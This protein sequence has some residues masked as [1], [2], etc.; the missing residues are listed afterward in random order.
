[1][2]RTEKLWRCDSNEETGILG[3]RPW[4][5]A[6]R[7]DRDLVIMEIVFAYA[8]GT[9]AADLE[10]QAAIIWANLAFDDTAKAALKRDGLAIEG[11]RLTGACP[12]KLRATDA[13]HVAVTAPGHGD[14]AALLDLWQI[15]FQRRIVLFGGQEAA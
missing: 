8:G 13:G 5:I 10:D 9:S 14:A 1:M 15:Y 3:K 12:F 2:R 7:F 4:G 11:L 6:R